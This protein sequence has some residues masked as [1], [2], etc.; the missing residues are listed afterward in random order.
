MTDSKKPIQSSPIFD[1]L[2]EALDDSG[3][4]A[5]ED[6]V[7]EV[8]SA[9]W[10]GF[11]DAD[12]ID[13]RI[14]EYVALATLDPLDIEKVRAIAAKEFA[15]KR[16]AEAGWPLITDCDR[17]D[18]AFVRLHELGI[19]AVHLAGATVQD[20]LSIV[21]D[22]LS[23]E[24]IPEDRYHGFCFY[25]SQDLDHALDGE[26]L[27]LAFGFVEGDE[28]PEQAQVEVGRLIC[29][30]LRHE[31]LKVDWSGTVDERIAL[32]QMQWQRRSPD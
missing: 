27:L 19:C 13:A 23:D 28:S 30:A 24:D 32:P 14:D 11:D 20:G 3:D 22:M 26:D 18:R 29:E 5:K 6:M 1:A 4:D 25:H 7:V 9:V 31:G 10:Y 12:A 2:D 21:S 16:I 15:K 17:L 8:V